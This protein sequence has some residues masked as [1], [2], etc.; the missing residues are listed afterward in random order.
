MNHSPFPLN[1]L[2]KVVDSLH[3]NINPGLYGYTEEMLSNGYAV[4]FDEVTT[5]A[6]AGRTSKVPAIVFM[7][8]QD[9]EMAHFGPEAP[10]D[11]HAIHC[12]LNIQ[13]TLVN[14]SYY[15][16]IQEHIPYPPNPS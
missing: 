13:S 2:V 4:A 12:A 3:S 15:D 8:F 1:V 16:S 6:L 11:N 14:E 10:A 9:L 5:S 7:R